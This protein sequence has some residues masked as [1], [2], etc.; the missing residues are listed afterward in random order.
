MSAQIVI[1]SEVEG[2]RDETLKV[3][4]RAPST[5]FGMTIFKFIVSP[6]KSG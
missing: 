5:A 6:A 1:P 2:S 3:P 4:Q